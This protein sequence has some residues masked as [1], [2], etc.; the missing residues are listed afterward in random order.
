MQA[1]Q[2]AVNANYTAVA[3]WLK[4]DLT[5]NCQRYRGVWE[6]ESNFLRKSQRKKDE[7]AQTNWR[8]ASRD[9]DPRPTDFLRMVQTV[10]FVSMSGF[11]RSN[12]RGGRGEEVNTHTVLIQLD[13]ESTS[14]A[15]RFLRA[16]SGLMALANALRYSRSF[17]LCTRFVNDDGPTTNNT[18][19]GGIRERVADYGGSQTLAL[20]SAPAAEYANTNSR[21][22][23]FREELYWSRRRTRVSTHLPCY[24]VDLLSKEDRR[25]TIGPAPPPAARR[26]GGAVTGGRRARQIVCTIEKLTTPRCDPWTVGRESFAGGALAGPSAGGRRGRACH[27]R[28]RHSGCDRSAEPAHVLSQLRANLTMMLLPVC[29]EAQ[30]EVLRTDQSR[31]LSLSHS[32]IGCRSHGY[33]I[34]TLPKLLFIFDISHSF[35][36]D[37]FSYPA[38]AVVAGANAIRDISMG[39]PRELSGGGPASAASDSRR[40]RPRADRGCYA[41]ATGLSPATPP[42]LTSIEF[43]QPMNV[44]RRLPTDRTGTRNPDPG[45]CRS[46]FFLRSLGGFV[47]RSGS[48]RVGAPVTA[49]AD[50]GGGRG[51]PPAARPGGVTGNVIGNCHDAVGLPSG[52]RHGGGRERRSA[53]DERGVRL[54]AVCSPAGASQA[55]H[56]IP[57]NRVL[58]TARPR[59]RT[60]LYRVRGEASL[61]TPPAGVADEKLSYD[62][63]RCV[64]PQLP[65]DWRRA[66]GARGAYSE[67]TNN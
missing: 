62:R 44:E 53:L 19:C 64:G 43:F 45:R 34:V 12:V 66:A 7:A 5:V 2:H 31:M 17:N 65:T 35:R 21:A 13:R 55:I 40:W 15:R 22:D 29:G 56:L 8:G 46:S 47:S 28:A 59:R 32:T 4:R 26:G 10:R 50:G 3:W 63:R 11:N 39:M 14:G 6:S 33:C 36:C 37:K 30:K 41:H 58:A 25:R 9:F 16:L 42:A 18:Y 67:D 52:Y 1:E 24:E 20:L 27:L 38:V 49:S 61:G 48:M 54:I 57:E 60:R 51:R 23:L